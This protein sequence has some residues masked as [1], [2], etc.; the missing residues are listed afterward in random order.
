MVRLIPRDEKF[1]DLFDEQSKLITK[2]AALLHELFKDPARIDEWTAAIKQ[3]EHEGD[4]VIR[5]VV[6][7]LNRSFVTP[8]DREDILMLASRLDNVIDRIDGTSRRAAQFRITEAREEASRLAELLEEATEQVGKAVAGMRN[9]KTMEEHNKRVKE[10]E[11]EGDGVYHSAMGRLFAG[12][13]DPIEVIKW[14]ELFDN[15]EDGLDRCDDV[16]N[17]L[18]SIS[19]KHG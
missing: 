13:P 5:E 17:A 8:L 18:K 14:K 12:S 15:L 6:T 3:V 2:A 9:Q 19:L 16:S 4:N 1:F 11:E 7:R 10:L